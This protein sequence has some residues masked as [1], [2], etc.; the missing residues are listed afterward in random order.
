MLALLMLMVCCVNAH[1]HD[2]DAK[3][4]TEHGL[5]ESLLVTIDDSDEYIIKTLHYSYRNNR[6]VS[7]RDLAYSLRGMSKQ[8]NVTVE[9]NRVKIL[10]GAEYTPVGGEGIPFPDIDSTTGDYYVYKTYDLM[11]NP[12]EL[13]GRELKYQS[14]MST[15]SDGYV[16]CF[17]SL[18]DVAMQL[19]LAIKF[20]G[21]GVALDTMGSCI[22][23]LDALEDEGFY[24]K[25]HTAL[26]GDAST[27]EVYAA[28]YPE[29]SVPIASTTKLMTYLV[30]KDA[31]ANK[32]ISADDLITVPQEAAELS[33]TE[34]GAIILDEGMEAPLDEL[35]AAM[36]LASSN[37]CALTLAVHV[38]GSE[39]A[40]VDLM[41][42]KADELG[43]SEEV[44]FYD[45][46]GLPIYTNNL[47]ATKVQN[48]MSAQDMFKLVRHILSVYPEITILTAQKV[49]TLEVLGV[50]V[51][52][53]NPL[54]YNV[55]G[56]IGLK[57]GTTNMAGDC[58]VVA[59]EA[60]DSEGQ[61]HFLIAIQFGAEDETIRA[62]LSEEL[63]RYAKQQLY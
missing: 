34:D 7:L 35:M 17:I 58:L 45:C 55:P 43:L 36:L 60:I 29:L 9:Q 31:L 23:D 1:A 25:I 16:D 8:F 47:A 5:L 14:F 44:R 48:R 39:E 51:T 4:L 42:N 61:T 27:G 38:A 3:H 62:T 26:V 13:D 6:F 46:H 15:G 37:E 2:A 30:I 11:V 41:K 53:T 22:I 19:D 63:I 50:T 33:R 24:Y 49:A 54:L 20:S 28:W 59:M 56:V 40:F 52:N 18:T 10:T 57:T 12:I 21:Q 32:N